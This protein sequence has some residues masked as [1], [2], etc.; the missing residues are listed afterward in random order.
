MKLTADNIKIIGEGQ[1]IKK[2][3]L[4]KYGGLEQFLLAHPIYEL[5][6]L[7]HYLKKKNINNPS[8]QIKLVSIFN[9]DYSDIY[10]LPDQ[11]VLNFLGEIESNVEKYNNHKDL[12]LMDKVIDLLDIIDKRLVYDCHYTKALIYLQIGQVDSAIGCLKIS[13]QKQEMYFKSLFE[14][15]FCY[16]LQ[17]K[18]IESEKIYIELM[19]TDMKNNFKLLY[20]Y[21]IL[22]NNTDRNMQAVKIFERAIEIT[23]NNRDIGKAIMNMATAYWK[24]AQYQK[25]ITEYNKALQFLN[26]EHDKS[27]VYNNIAQAYI[28]LQNY[29]IAYDNADKALENV[30]KDNSKIF[31]NIYHTFCETS[32]ALGNA[33]CINNLIDLCREMYQGYIYKGYL[34][35]CMEFAIKHSNK[36]QLEILRDFLTKMLTSNVNTVETKAFLYDI[37]IR[38]TGKE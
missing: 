30:E 10:I 28:K 18:Y 19:H 2:L 32:I 20:R 21:G 26:T 15:A 22:L 14:L 8:L 5:S 23:N 12:D 6:T 24:L 35:N 4:Q 36:K 33:E 31:L 17:K 37:I 38:E 13:M 1:Q 29:T 9:M 34:H 11:Q 25:S 27:I 16:F 3:L 7:K